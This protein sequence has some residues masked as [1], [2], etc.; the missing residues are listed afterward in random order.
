MVIGILLLA[1]SACSSPAGGRGGEVGPNNAS[2]TA[3]PAA[4]KS[5]TIGIQREPASFE[6]ELVGAAASSG[7]GGGLQYRPIAQDNLT[8]PGK[9]GELEAR[10]AIEMPTL[11]NSDWR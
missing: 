6:P 11:E 1:S 10:L 5:V 7:A 4:S 3:V 9:S 2:P 8:V